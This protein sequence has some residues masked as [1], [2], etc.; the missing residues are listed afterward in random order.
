MGTLNALHGDGVEQEVDT[1]GDGKGDTWQTYRVNAHTFNPN[2]EGGS[3]DYDESVS[4]SNRTDVRALNPKT[5]FD[6]TNFQPGH[7]VIMTINKLDGPDS[8]ANGKTIG[9]DYEYPDGTVL[10][11][12]TDTVGQDL[13]DNE[14]WFIWAY[15]GLRPAARGDASNEEI[16]SNETY[17]TRVYADGYS[18]I[19]TNHTMSNLDTSL[20]TLHLGKEGY[21]WVEGENLAFISWMGTKH[22]M[23]HDGSNYGTP[24]SSKSGFVWIPNNSGAKYIEYVDANGTQRRTKLGDTMGWRGEDNMPLSTS[25]SNKGYIWTCDGFNWH[26][27]M[28]INTDGDK[29]RIG[30]GYL[31]GNEY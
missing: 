1:D 24:G 17:S 19:N 29:V 31:N 5:D 8:N 15:T 20:F 27:L 12:S 10:F 14:F 23:L 16:H 11:S 7:E 13:G 28:F 9:I 30:N 2:T 21:I 4:G 22:T 6:L 3:N 25:T 18:D 26:A